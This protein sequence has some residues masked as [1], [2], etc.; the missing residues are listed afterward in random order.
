MTLPQRLGSLS[1]GNNFQQPVE[2]L[3]HLPCLETLTFGDAFNQAIQRLPGSLKSLSFGDD[4]QQPLEQL[5]YEKK[6]VLV[7]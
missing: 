6:H 4:F 3:V 2:T 5:N 7:F 1:F